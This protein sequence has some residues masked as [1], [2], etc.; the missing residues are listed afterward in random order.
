M[1]SF[2]PSSS[3]WPSTRVGA[4]H[5]SVLVRPHIELISGTETIGVQRHTASK[6]QR[7]VPTLRFNRLSPSNLVRCFRVHH[8]LEHMIGPFFVRSHL[9]HVV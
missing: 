9:N 5:G 4:F 8:S 1:V 3:R 6:Q 7:R 2:T